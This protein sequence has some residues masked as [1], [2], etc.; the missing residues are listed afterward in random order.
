MAASASRS[1]PTVSLLL[2]LLFLIHLFSPMVQPMNENE[3]SLAEL[4]LPSNSPHVTLSDAYGHD[5]AGTEL[6]FDGLPSATVREESA[7][8]YWMS[9][10]VATLPNHT[11]GTPDLKLNHDEGFDVCWTTNE[12]DVYVGS[13]DAGMAS[14]GS[15]DSAWTMY[16]V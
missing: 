10:V 2:S 9:E 5:F 1:F 11:M 4:L 7:L 12:G 13:L 15:F 14:Q 16:L 6:S 3:D 8:D